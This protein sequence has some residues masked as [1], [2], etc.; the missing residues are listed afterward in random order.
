LL[1]IGTS[2]GVGKSVVVAGPCRWLA[3][4]GMSVAPLKAQNTSLNSYVTRA[5]EGIGRAQAAQAWACSIEPEAAMGPVLLKPGSGG[6]AQLIVLGRAVGEHEAGRYR[7]DVQGGLL[8]VVTDAFAN[9][10]ARFDVVI[11]EGAG[12][13]AEVNLRG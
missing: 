10:A 4:E 5:G 11:C 2:S 9:L 13:P 3:P 1:V 8:G 12:S 7:G 6:T